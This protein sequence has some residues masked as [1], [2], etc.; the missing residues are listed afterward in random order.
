MTFLQWLSSSIG[1]ALLL[2]VLG[3]LARHWIITRITNSI[4]HEY[5]K[6]LETHKS[7]LK[8]DYDVQIE[9]LKAEL[10]EKKFR[11]SHVFE[12]TA[13]TI[14]T[15]YAKL[16]EMKNTVN[17]YTFFYEGLDESE[18]KEM[19]SRLIVTRRDFVNYFEKNRIY[20]PKST[21]DKIVSFSE[22]LHRMQLKYGNVMRLEQA[23]VSSNVVMEHSAEYTN[24]F[25]QVPEFQRLLEDDFQKI[26]GFPIEEKHA[27][28]KAH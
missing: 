5:D 9:K 21:A 8:R 10:A 7:D 19:I 23:N 14:A 3:F 26:L 15:T 27:P 11:F 6:E 16:V 2:A 18:K 12:R 28:V 20:I 25:E 1:T 24:L 13:E 4:K 22:T 17:A